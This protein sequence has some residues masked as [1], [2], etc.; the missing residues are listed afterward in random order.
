MGTNGA[1]EEG[2]LGEVE[3]PHMG[4]GKKPTKPLLPCYD[5]SSSAPFLFSTTDTLETDN[6]DFKLCE[7]LKLGGGRAG[8]GKED[9][10]IDMDPAGAII[11]WVLVILEAWAKLKVSWAPNPIA[12]FPVPMLLDT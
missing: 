12:K 7:V 9:E 5:H 6:Y 8:G 3:G 10:M 2:D 4:I 11:T 1:G